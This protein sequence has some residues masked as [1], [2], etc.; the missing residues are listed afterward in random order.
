MSSSDSP[1]LPVSK[2]KANELSSSDGL[3][4]PTSHCPVQGN[5]FG[6]GPTAQSSTGELDAERSRQLRP[7]EGGLAYAVVVAGRTGPQQPSGLHKPPAK[8]SD[9]YELTASSEAATRH[10]LRRHVRALPLCVM[11]VGTTSSAE[12]ATNCFAPAVKQQNKTSIYVSRVRDTRG[13]LTWIRTSCHGR[14]SDQIKGRGKCLS[15]EP[16]TASGPWSADC[17]P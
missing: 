7:I 12:V 6:E 5:L 9:H 1:Q 14:L 2:R 17:D 13:Y 11:P 8:V 3:S 10:V 16:L 15:H 4:E